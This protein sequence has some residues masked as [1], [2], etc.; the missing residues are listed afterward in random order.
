[1]QLDLPLAGA[2]DVEVALYDLRGRRVALLH[3]GPL[4][5][6]GPHG[7]SWDGRDDEGRG[8]ASGVYLARAVADG[9]MLTGKVA[10]VR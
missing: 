9:R 5:G 2:R 10:L 6:A 4:D 3:R 1:V 7:F 8:V